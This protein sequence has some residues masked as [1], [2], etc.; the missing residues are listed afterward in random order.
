M[1][2]M[3]VKEPAGLLVLEV[4]QPDLNCHEAIILELYLGNFSKDQAEL[5]PYLKTRL[6]RLHPNPIPLP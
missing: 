2:F 4:S 1:Y 3:Y 5:L 6:P